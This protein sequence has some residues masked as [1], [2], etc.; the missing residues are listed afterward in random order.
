MKSFLNQTKNR[1]TEFFQLLSKYISQGE[2]NQTSII[3][4]YYVLLSIFPIIIIIGNVL[5]LFSIDTKPI[6]RYLELI[7][8]SQ[9]SSLIM[10]IINALLKKHSSGIIS[11]GIVIA[12]WSLSCLVNSVRLAANKIYGVDKKE[13]GK[14][15]WNYLLARTFTFALSVILVAGFSIIIFVFTFGRQIMEFLAPIF[16]LSLW[17]VYKLE[18]YRWPII[19]LMTVIINLYINY[20]I[21]NISVQKRV[22][23]PGGCFTVASWGALSYFFGLYLRQFGTRWQNYGIVGS[24]IIFMLWLNIGSFL[25]LLGICINATGDELKDRKIEYS[26]SPILRIFRKNKKLPK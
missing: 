4:A 25:L 24:F 16:N 1:I 11:L 8:P 19:I 9:V 10:P 15:W 13:K 26:R 18:N 14:S 23:W 20:V 6:A 21:P 17:W 3:I 12:I 5:P 22:V 7:F 2:I